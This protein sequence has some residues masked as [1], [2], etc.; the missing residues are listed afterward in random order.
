MNKDPEQNCGRFSFK[1]LK[2]VTDL[3]T[4]VCVK[5]PETGFT[6]STTNSNKQGGVQEPAD[7]FKHRSVNHSSAGDNK[8][9]SL[10]LCTEKRLPIR[11]QVDLQK[12]FLWFLKL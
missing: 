10:N 8:H 9:L 3:K 4:V 11:S 12:T 7:R 2:L 1:G 5:A 6:G